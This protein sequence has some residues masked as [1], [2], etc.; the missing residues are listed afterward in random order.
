[1]RSNQ[2]SLK[3][4]QK[5]H[6]L[7]QKIKPQLKVKTEDKPNNNNMRM[8]IAGTRASTVGSTTHC[9]FLGCCGRR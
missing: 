9:R 3:C 2:K 7:F 8:K 4:S 6:L 1:M 5:C